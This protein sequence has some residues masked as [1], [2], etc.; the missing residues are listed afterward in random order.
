M[1]KLR[2]N[3]LADK[4]ITDRLIESDGFTINNEQII[5]KQLV[6]PNIT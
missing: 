3:G 2:N 5:P 1:E 4:D 6:N